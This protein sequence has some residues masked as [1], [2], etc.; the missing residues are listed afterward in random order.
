MEHPNEFLYYTLLTLKLSCK[1]WLSVLAG[2][3]LRSA[4]RETQA[5]PPHINASPLN[6]YSIQNHCV[7]AQCRDNAQVN[8]KMTYYAN[9][10]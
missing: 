1:R 9:A 3:V 10:S 4:K 6:T 2:L 5:N 8:R 7:S